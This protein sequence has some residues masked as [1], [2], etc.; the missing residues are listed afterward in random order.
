MSP[1]TYKPSAQELPIVRASNRSF[2]VTYATGI[3][4][5]LGAG[6]S[7][8]RAVPANRRFWVIF[9]VGIAGEY[10]GRKF[11]E[12]RARSVLLHDLPQDSQL[13]EIISKNAHPSK[14]LFDVGLEGTVP[15]TLANAGSSGANSEESISAWERIRQVNRPKTQQQQDGSAWGR[16]RNRQQPQALSPSL[17]EEDDD[18]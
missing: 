14:G 11:G 13:R 12:A 10:A 9:G 15:P 17:P 5:G 4:A 2:L 3:V 1:Q 18:F 8:S 16:I 6:F 7:L